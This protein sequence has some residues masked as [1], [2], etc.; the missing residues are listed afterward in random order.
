[1]APNGGLLACSNEVLTMIF[2]DPSLEKT[3]IKSLRLT[4]KELHPAATREFAMRYLAEPY[5]VLTRDS[6]QSL[7]DM[8]KHPIFGPQIRSIGFLATTLEVQ[9]LEHRI[10]SVNSA[11]AYRRNDDVHSISSDLTGISDYALLC[12]DQ[13]QLEANRETKSLILSAIQ[14][15]DHPISISVTNDLESIGY[16]PVIGLSPM[17][18]RRNEYSGRRV[19]KLSEINSKMMGLF[20]AIEKTIARLGSKHPMSL[21]GLKLHVK[22][23]PQSTTSNSH[24]DYINMNDVGVYSNLES[25]HLD[26]SLEAIRCY[27][28]LRSL[29]LLFKAA[30]KLQR[31]VFVT[32][33]TGTRAIG[34]STLERVAK[35]L[36]FETVFELKALVLENVP[37]TSETL[38]K[39]MERYKQTL[40]E[41]KLS[42]VTL[43]G[44]WKPCL[45]WIR[46][47]LELESLHISH[48]Q[49]ISRQRVTIRG[50]FKPTEQSIQGLPVLLLHGRENVRVG[51][52]N[53]FSD[54]AEF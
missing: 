54:A 53:M 50:V 33:C 23:R 32:S 20:S 47:N 12:R 14:A 2:N 4:S 36:E 21:V 40:V 42:R 9:G 27:M 48:P 25:L 38:L 10:G 37:C 46:K 18:H 1:M 30:A 3:D 43:L 8:C 5:F 13:L 39:L 15:L 6:L 17:I 16:N 49:T 51:L 34:M 28:S 41:V 52:D 45:S 19:A 35:I 11:T 31:L 29:E 26:L 44:H 22:H 24:A 7:A